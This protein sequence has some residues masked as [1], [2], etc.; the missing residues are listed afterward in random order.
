MQNTE[1]LK[2][3]TNPKLTCTQITQNLKEVN[4]NKNDSCSINEDWNT[5]SKNEIQKFFNRSVLLVLY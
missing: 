4:W 5:Q 1:K 2:L 3:S